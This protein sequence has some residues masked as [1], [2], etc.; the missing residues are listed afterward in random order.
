MNID[1]MIYVEPFAFRKC[2]FGILSGESRHKMAYIAE[3][4]IKDPAEKALVEE[5]LKKCNMHNRKYFWKVKRTVDIIL[6][7]VALIAFAPI[8]LLIGLVIF[9]FD[10]HNPI[11]KQTRAGRFGKEFEMY[12]FRTMVSDAEAR[13]GELMKLNKMDGP[14]FKVDN[15]PRITKAGK[16]LRMTSLDEL[17]QL[18]NVIKGDMTIIGPRPPLP[19]EVASYTEHQK[20]RLLVT[21]GLTCIWQVQPHRNDIPFGRW[22][23]MDIDYIL[24]R[25]L[26][27]DISIVFKTILAMIRKDGE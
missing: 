8:M 21:P 27:M 23:E 9:C 12:K 14:V 17:P 15:D 18:I 6:S 5:I 25:N 20:I 4:K 2:V 1:I 10:G 11:F 7:L 22:V 26:A 24:H 3:E 13:K 16:F 19:S